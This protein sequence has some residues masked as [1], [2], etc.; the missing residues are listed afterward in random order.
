MSAVFLNSTLTYEE[1]LS[2]TDRIRRREI[3]LLYMAPETLLRSETLLMLD[4]CQMDCLTIDEA[5][6]ISEWGHDF[7]PEYRQLAQ[8]RER[9]PNVVC[10]A[11]T[12]TATPD[13]RN[14]IR[15]ILGSRM[16]EFIASFDRPNL[17]IAVKPRV[18]IH[19]QIFDFLASHRNQS[20]IIYCATRRQVDELHEELVAN[21]I[22]VLPYHAGL[23]TEIREQNQTAFI[24]DNARIIVATIAFGMGIDKPNVRFV[25]HAYLP[26]YIECYYQ[27]IGRAGRDGLRADCLLLF[28]YGDVD[29]IQYFIQQG[30]ATEQAGRRERLTALVDWATA[31]DLSSYRF[32]GPFRRR[33]RG[34]QLS[35]VRQLSD[36]SGRTG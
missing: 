32:V 16:N 26:K 30:A 34:G 6:C 22:S 21:D 9:F 25:V 13:V 7:R 35:D 20:G 23:D 28:S 15:Q 36:R 4:E 29:T 19:Q 24:R 11:L 18:D 5:H 31:T 1:R 2:T 8:M 33:I 27:E 3:K 14:D 12:A 17:F 10:V